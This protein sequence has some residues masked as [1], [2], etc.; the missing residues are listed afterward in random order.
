MC[1]RRVIPMIRSFSSAG[2][3][4][5]NVA[6]VRRGHS[7]MRFDPN[8]CGDTMRQLMHMQAIATMQ[9]APT[10]CVIDDIYT[11]LADRLQT[12]VQHGIARERIVCDPGF[13]FG[14]TVRHNVDLLN[15]LPCFRSLGQPLLVGTSRK[16]FLGRLLKREVWDR[17]EGTMA[18]A[19]Y[20][21]ILGATFVRVHDVS[22]IAQAMRMFDAVR[23]PEVERRSRA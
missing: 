11:F 19:M 10:L 14:K 8:V 17:L 21:A 12:A 18:S 9:Q 16:S 15:G 22:P 23:S 7:A 1:R 5:A 2:H 20:A 4:H 3:H 13:G 6:K